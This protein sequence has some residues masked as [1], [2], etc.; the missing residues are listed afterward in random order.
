MKEYKAIGLMSGTSLDGLDMALVRFVQAHGQWS[1]E[2]LD[3]DTIPYNSFWRDKLETA[4]K[5]DGES[6]HKLH[7][8]YGHFLGMAVSEFIRKTKIQP[9]LVA[10]HGHT[11]FHNPSQGYTLQIGS[12]SAIASH[13][14]CPVVFD[15]R[16]DDVA[17]GGQGA[18]LVPIGDE[19][20]FGEYAACINL[21]GFANISLNK[22]GQ[23]MAW[24]IGPANFIL[25]PI[26]QKLGY[27]YDNK[28]DM[29]RKGSVN[30][31]LLEVLNNLDY[32]K[33][34]SPKSIGREWIENVFEPAIKPFTLANYDLLRTFTAHI[35]DQV[36]MAVKGKKGKVLFTGGGAKNSFLMERITSKSGADI[37]IP[38]NEIIDFKEAVIFAFMG[39]LRLENQ[40]NILNS[41]TGASHSIS[42]GSCIYPGKQD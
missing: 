23:R 12:G 14:D 31:A 24:D 35:S 34:S 40:V 20:L 22:D 28:G 27:S 4:Q 32:Y 19:L 37:Y 16:S 5:L 11:I 2:L 7:M 8:D 18:P 15:F 38:E 1:F 41:V 42:A 10:S 21:G 3:S 36:S 30:M 13:V 29:A 9:D 25:N 17:L 33:L 26:A 39:V 6:L